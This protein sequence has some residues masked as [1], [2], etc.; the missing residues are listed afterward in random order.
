ML[1]SC[2]ALY[3]DAQKKNYAG[4]SNA[5]SAVLCSGTT[6][7]LLLTTDAPYHFMRLSVILNSI[8]LIFI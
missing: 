7:H 2:V 3:T 5:R 8:I 1:L 6:G 4:S